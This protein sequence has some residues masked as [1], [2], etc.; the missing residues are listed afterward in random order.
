[1]SQSIPDNSTKDK[2]LAKFKSIKVTHG[3]KH[4]PFSQISKMACE[5]WLK[6]HDSF[7][8]IEEIDQTIADYRKEIK[9]EQ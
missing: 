6:T 4:L 3:I 1:M 2:V 7:P 5:E 9:N 8:T